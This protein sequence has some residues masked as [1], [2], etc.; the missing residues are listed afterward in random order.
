MVHVHAELYTCAYWPVI[1]VFVPTYRPNNIPV[2]VAI[3]GERL[4]D[5]DVDQIFKLTGIE[6]DLDGNIKYAGSFV[7]DVAKISSLP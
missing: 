1:I 7:H 4:P 2:H 5:G 6:E 3:T